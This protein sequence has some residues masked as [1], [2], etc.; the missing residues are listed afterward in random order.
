MRNSI[1]RFRKI[2]ITII[3]MLTLQKY[4]KELQ[5]KWCEIA[6][7][8]EL[9]TYKEVT[10]ENTPHFWYSKNWRVAYVERNK[11]DDSMLLS[12]PVRWHIHNVLIKEWFNIT[13]DDLLKTVW[14]NIKYIQDIMDMLYWKSDKIKID[15]YSEVHNPKNFD[16][17]MNFYEKK[18]NIIKK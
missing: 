2:I 11:D 5:R 10:I 4:I 16:K 8:K 9:P 18:Y 14:D 15:N 6:L 17:F 7:P 12:V 3:K 13:V 1:S